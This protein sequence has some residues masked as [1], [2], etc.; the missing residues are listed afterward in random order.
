MISF[1]II[2]NP[3]K[4]LFSL[5]IVICPSPELLQAQYYPMPRTAPSKV[6]K[7]LS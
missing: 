4:I 2:S 1:I 5:M 6:Y 7:L 3:L